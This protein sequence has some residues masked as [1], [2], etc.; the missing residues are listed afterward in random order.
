MQNFVKDRASSGAWA[1]V[2]M[3]VGCAV[4]ALAGMLVAG[5][6]LGAVILL[7]RGIVSFWS[8]T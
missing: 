3:V 4:T 5:L 6:A 8:S 1:P 2:Q 7:I